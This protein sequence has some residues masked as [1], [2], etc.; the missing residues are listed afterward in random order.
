M[1]TS[2]SEN[3]V[4][5]S[6]AIYALWPGCA[7]QPEA[8]KAKCN[9]LKTRSAV[10]VW[11]CGRGVLLGERGNFFC[12]L[13]NASQIREIARLSRL[14][15]SHTAMT[16][17]GK[18]TELHFACC[19][20]DPKLIIEAVKMGISVNAPDD[21]RH[22]FRRVELMRLVHHCTRQSALNRGRAGALL[23]QFAPLHSACSVCKS[24]SRLDSGAGRANGPGKRSAILYHCAEL[25]PIFAEKLHAASCG[26]AI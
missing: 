13:H 3:H 21:V 6:L 15:V 22:P 19:R 7:C 18:K 1:E 16:T 12:F 9:A 24:C 17:A 26:C 10:R 25:M 11:Q 23:P 2:S 14:P 8:E 20:G 4:D 5:W